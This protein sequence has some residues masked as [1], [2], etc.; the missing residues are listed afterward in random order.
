MMAMCSWQNCMF[1]LHKFS[2]I[3]K[4]RRAPVASLLNILKGHESFFFFLNLE[5]IELVGLLRKIFMKSSKTSVSE[6]MERQQLRG[7]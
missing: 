7:S 3:L 2:F 5:Y 6:R 1:V 4:G